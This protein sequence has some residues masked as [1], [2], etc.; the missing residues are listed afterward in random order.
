MSHARNTYANVKKKEGPFDTNYL[1]KRMGTGTPK[2]RKKE[3]VFDRINEKRLLIPSKTTIFSFS[4]CQH[5]PLLRLTKDLWC[6]SAPPHI[7]PSSLIPHPLISHLSIKLTPPFS[8]TLELIIPLIMT[9]ISVW[10]RKKEK[11]K[12]SILYLVIKLSGTMASVVGEF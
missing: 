9:I 5:L 3:G 1:K 7:T 4:K 6:H 8:I 10:E 12:G 11:K 2:R